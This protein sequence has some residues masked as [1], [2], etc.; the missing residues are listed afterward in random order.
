MASSALPEPGTEYGPCLEACE[1]RDCAATRRDA[2]ELCTICEKPIGYGR[3]HYS[4]GEQRADG[5]RPLV[6]AV[7]F[8]EKVERE[9]AGAP[10]FYRAQTERGWWLSRD[11]EHWY[12]VT[13]RPTREHD[14]DGVLA[15]CEPRREGNTTVAMVRV[16]TRGLRIGL[17]GALLTEPEHF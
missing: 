8:E 13:E 12:P 14:C 11:G 16:V 10:A 4:D 6:H 3:H 2:A 15:Q 5:S 7:C 17:F 9:R 1:H